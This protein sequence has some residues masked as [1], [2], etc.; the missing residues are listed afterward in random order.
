MTAWYDGLADLRTAGFRLLALTPDPTAVPLS[1]AVADG[2]RAAAR[3]R[4][5]R[6]VVR[7]LHEADQ[8]VRIPIHP[9]ALAAGWPN[10]V[11]AAA[12]A[13]HVLVGVDQARS[14]DDLDFH[15]GP[16]LGEHEGDPRQPRRRRGVRDN[17]SRQPRTQHDVPETPVSL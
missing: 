14:V 3:H 15:V 6:P 8:A 16:A 12:I 1:A 5:R 11:A 10:V 9:G 7:W 4:G 13:C 2:R 17:G